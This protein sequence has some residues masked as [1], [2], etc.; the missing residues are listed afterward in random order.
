MKQPKI[1]PPQYL[2]PW[3]EAIRSSYKNCE[4]IAYTFGD[5]NFPLVFVESKL[6][7]N[8]LISIPFVDFGGPIGK[9]DAQFIV[10]SIQHMKKQSN[11]K[12]IEIRLNTFMENY[13]KTE[14]VLFEEGFSKESNRSQ[15]ILE[16][17]D[18]EELWNSFNRI[19]RKG[20][21]KAHKSDL[22]IKEI[23]NERELKNFYKMY[24]ESMRDFGTPQHSYKYFENLSTIAKENFKGLNCYKDDVLISSLIVLH[25]KSY[26]YAAYNFSKSEY[27]KYQPNDLLYWEMI[28]WAVDNNI[29]YFDFGQ[30]E[31][32]A[33]E[34]THAYG[35][36]KFKSKRNG[37]L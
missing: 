28:K 22:V 33:K 27:L 12:H 11:L 18:E 6:F 13:E 24:L 16:L 26:M 7:G 4:P 8:R 10:D 34:G 14:K 2:W 5:S 9:F 20:I 1:I 37:N 3:E 35:I 36:Y 19:T 31:P 21:R 17:K 29:Q 30:C 15:F 32:K 23:D 25:S